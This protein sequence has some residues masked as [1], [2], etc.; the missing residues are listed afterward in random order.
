[1]LQ[2]IKK[3]KRVYFPILSAFVLILSSF[4]LKPGGDSFEIYLNNKLIMQQYGSQM[5]AVKNLQ[6]DQHLATDELLVKYHHCGKVGK[7]RVIIIKDE[8]NNILKEWHFPNVSSADAGMNCSVKDILILKK[9]NIR[10]VKL[11]YASAELPKGRLLAS[12]TFGTQQ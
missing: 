6:L 1:M 2:L 3:T 11:Y 7:E 8:Q 12:I 10:Q 4:S 9:G 5:D